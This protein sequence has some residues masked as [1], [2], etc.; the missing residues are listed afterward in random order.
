MKSGAHNDIVLHV[1]YE[2]PLWWHNMWW[3]RRRPYKPWYTPDPYIAST[4]IL[5]DSD[6]TCGKVYLM[7]GEHLLQ[8]SLVT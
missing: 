2:R 7:H 5:P 1:S 6:D 8:C 4:T 3:L